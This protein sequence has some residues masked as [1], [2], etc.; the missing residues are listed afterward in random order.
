MLEHTIKQLDNNNIEDLMLLEKE[1]FTESLEE[2]RNSFLHAADIYPKGSVLLYIKGKIAGS[3]FFHPYMEGVIKDINSNNFVLSGKENCMYLYSFSIHSDFK[4]KGLTHI[5]FDHFNKVS[6]E[7]GYN[8]QALIAIQ[9]SERFW[10]RYGFNPVRQVFYDNS[11][12]T[13]MTRET[14]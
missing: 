4:G 10:M 9:N 7:E 3:L 5:L 12:S 1:C 8:V 11:L 14:N 13:Y 2:D 6:L